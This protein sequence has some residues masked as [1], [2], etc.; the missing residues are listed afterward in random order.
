[1]TDLHL[2]GHVILFAICFLGSLISYQDEEGRLFSVTIFIT[3]VFF[4][5]IEAIYWLLY[6]AI[7]GIP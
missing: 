2:L 1:M 6:W 3:F 7:I 5:I 4:F